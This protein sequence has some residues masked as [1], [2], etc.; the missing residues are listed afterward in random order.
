MR[1][2]NDVTDADL[3]KLIDHIDGL[4]ERRLAARAK[5]PKMTTLTE[6]NIESI[7]E[8]GVYP[9]DD[10]S[11]GPRLALLA[12][13]ETLGRVGGKDLMLRVLRAYSNKYGSEKAGRLSDRWQT[14]AE[15]WY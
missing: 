11:S 5:K 14:A 2:R 12:V 13:G 4:M 10:P 15:I 3:A 7:L 9:P 1:R 8:H 6:I